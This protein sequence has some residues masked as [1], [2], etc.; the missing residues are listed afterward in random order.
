MVEIR[1]TRT[2]AAEPQPIWDVLAD[3]GALSAWAD[4][5]DHSCLLEHGA[6]GPQVGTSRRVQVGRNTLVERITDVSPPRTLGYD[7]EGL[8]SRLK[9]GNRWTLTPTA[10]GRSEVAVT[11]TVN[12][13]AN[14]VAG[15]VERVLGR[16]LAK[17]SD[18]MLAGL[19]K[20]MEARNV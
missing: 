4:N 11:T 10:N 17:Q 2:V 18:A 5:V 6:D 16:F 20:R 8:P 15:L 19:A 13:G 3:F 14:P 12:L 1:R 9:V 7:I